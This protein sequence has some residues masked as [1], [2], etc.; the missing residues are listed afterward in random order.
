VCC[1]V[2]QFVAVCCS[3][4]RSV[5]L[6]C[7]SV[8]AYMRSYVLCA[9]VHVC[10]ICVIYVHCMGVYTHSY[11]ICCTG[12]P[13]ANARVCEGEGARAQMSVLHCVAVSCRVLLCVAVCCS[14][15]C[16]VLQ[17]FAL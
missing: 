12:R 1:S 4:S 7:R 3:V 10:F 9:S 14:V 11:L 5:L 2:L 15:R 8:L 17:C 16:S 13:I 6:V